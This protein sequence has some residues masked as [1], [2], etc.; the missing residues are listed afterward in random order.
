MS[1]TTVHLVRHGEVQNPDGILYG[2]LAGF[3]LS[4]RGHR[5]AERVVDALSDRPVTHVVASPLERARQTAQPLARRIGLEVQPEPRVVEAGSRLEGLRLAG[6]KRVFRTPVAWRHLWNPVRP[7]WG[8]PYEEVVARM[9]A[10]VDDARA[11]A[12]GHEA[13][14]VTH[15]LPIWALRLRLEGRR[16]V[17]DPR[18]RQC[19]LCSITSLQFDDDLLTAVTYSEPAADLQEGRSP[20]VQIS[21]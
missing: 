19:S 20:R 8:E 6:A 2:R 12:R 18:R 1:T 16:L 5:M 17:H 15:Q 10:A 14:I 21:E 4:E 9:T 11:A 3:P 7:S 13:V